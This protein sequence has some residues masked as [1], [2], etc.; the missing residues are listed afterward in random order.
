M[1]TN[2]SA[3]NIKQFLFDLDQQEAKR[4]KDMNLTEENYEIA[5][6]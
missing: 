5:Q 2:N 4:L 6:G 1:N 3:T